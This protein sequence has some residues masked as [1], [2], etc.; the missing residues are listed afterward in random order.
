MVYISYNNFWG[1]EFD[2]I[3]PN[4]DKLQDLNLNQLKPHK[5][6]EKI[7]TDFEPTDDSDVIDKAYLDVNLLEINGNLSKLEKDYNE[8][9]LQ[10]NKQTVE[11]ILIRRALKATVQILYDKGLFDIY[12]NA[13]SVLEEF[14]FTTRRRGKLSEQVKDDVQ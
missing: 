3:D 8:L 4:R 5:K 7:T 9:K 6:D 13:E 10:H 11:G 12:A 1:S 2:G 14:L